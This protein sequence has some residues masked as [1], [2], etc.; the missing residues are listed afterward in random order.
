MQLLERLD[1]LST[2]ARR[3]P[4]SLSDA[5]LDDLPRLYRAAAS[6]ASRFAT[7]GDQPTAIRESKRVLAQAHAQLH[8]GLR[9][10]ADPWHVRLARLVFID[11]ARAIRAEWRIVGFWMV[12]FYGL[13]FLG[14]MLAASDLALAFRLMPT[15]VASDAIAKL[16]ALAPGAAWEGNFT[17]TFDESSSTAGW[18]MAN[19]L[20]VTALWMISGVLPPLLAWMFA[21]FAL[22]TGAYI[23]IASHWGQTGSI[24]SILM[25]HGTFEL[26]AAVLS[27]SA[28]TM[29]ARGI[30][31]P[32]G[33]SRSHAIRNAGQLAL[34]LFAPT[35]PL[36][37]AAGLIEGYVS[38]HAPT[39]IRLTIAVLSAAIMIVWFGWSGRARKQ[40]TQ[41][42]A[43]DVTVSST[44]RALRS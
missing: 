9:R 38:P 4:R 17:F 24:M 5:Q 42:Q 40:A 28:G 32:G 25:C 19:N 37:I 34:R 18:I 6:I 27:G 29:I 36:L 2:R 26:T 12:L 23:G 41:S 44:A 22:Q 30:V 1:H 13:M 39:S 33:F 7:R 15:E 10:E 35:V 14:Y 43:D 11:S 21:N 31:A 3:K 20:Y 8:A 16:D